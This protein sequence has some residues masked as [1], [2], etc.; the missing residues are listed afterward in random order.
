VPAPASTAGVEEVGDWGRKG[1]G[2]QK[3]LRVRVW[4]ARP[5]DAKETGSGR[6]EGKG[7]EHGRRE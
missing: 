1:L 6:D 3:D 7:G 4:E 2:E 5:C